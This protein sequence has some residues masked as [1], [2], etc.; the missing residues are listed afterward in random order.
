MTRNQAVS[1]LASHGVPARASAALAEPVSLTKE[2][3]RSAGVVFMDER[4]NR[5]IGMK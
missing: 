1:L 3:Q 4:A 5:C 2:D